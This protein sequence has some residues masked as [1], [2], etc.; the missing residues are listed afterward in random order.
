MSDAA[1]VTVGFASAAGI[2]Q[3]DHPHQLELIG[4]LNSTAK[5]GVMKTAPMNPISMSV[6]GHVV[7]I[8]IDIRI[9]WI[10]TEN[11]NGTKSCFSTLSMNMTTD[12]MF[13]DAGAFLHVNTRGVDSGLIS[14]WNIGSI[15]TSCGLR[16]SIQNFRVD[17]N[18]DYFDLIATENTEI[19]IDAST[20]RYC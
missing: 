17:F 8:I 18:P 10:R 5:T 13:V 6:A 2:V 1:A 11:L 4:A 7:L 12:R 15:A 16:H 14:D 20:W 19:I 3:M 9:A